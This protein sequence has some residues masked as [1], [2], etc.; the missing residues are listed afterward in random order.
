MNKKVVVIITILALVTGL[1]AG[2]GI[3][4]Y[5]YTVFPQ[6]KAAADAEKQQKALEQMVRSGEVEKVTPEQI[7]MKIKDAP[8]DKGKTKTYRINEYTQVQVG[9]KFVSKPGAKT[10][11]TKYFKKGDTVSLLVKNDQ[12]VSV[13]RE[14]SIHAPSRGATNSKT[15]P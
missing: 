11:L 5:K 12:A 7:T 15:V 13:Y 4:Y 14:V 10:D 9:M 1:S 6:K 8:K 2:I 3:G